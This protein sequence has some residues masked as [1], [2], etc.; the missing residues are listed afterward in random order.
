MKLRRVRYDLLRVGAAAVTT[1]AILVLN[2]SATAAAAEETQPATGATTQSAQP[3]VLEEIVVTAQRRL[4]NLQDVPITVTAMPAAALAAVG[5]TN[6]ADLVNVVPG[7]LVQ[8]SAGYSLPHLRGVGITAIG[9]GIEN[10]VALYVDGVYRGVSSSDAVGL[11]N[12]AQVEVEKGPQGTL[13]G[14]N[15]TGGLIQ[16]T[17]LDPTAGFSA[18]AHA[19]YGNYHTVQSDAY[20]S[21]GTDFVAGDLAVQLTHQGE[22]Y[23]T[24]LATGQDINRMDMSLSVR[25]KWILHPVDGT[26]LT[27]I[28]DNAETDNS[29]SALR[30]YQNYPNIYYPGGMPIANLPTLDVDDDAQPLR[31]MHEQGASLQLDQDIDTVK[32]VNTVAYRRDVYTY[33]VDFDLGPMPYSLNDTRQEDNQLTEELRLLSN[34]NSSLTWMTGLFYYGAHNGF[35]PQNIYFSGTAVNPAKPVTHVLNETVQTT[36]SLALFG[37]ATQK[38]T[39]TT[40]LTVGLRYTGE[41]RALL[42]TDTGF[43]NGVVPVPLANVNTN[44]RTN[45]PTWRL[46]LDHHFTDDVNGY[47]SYNRG[48]KSG[49]YNVP[50]PALPAYS[51]EK[52]DAYETGLKTQFLERRLTLNTAF[53]YYNYQNIQVSRF[54]N[55]SPEV[56][57]GGKARLYGLDLDATV[58][59]TQGL[60]ISAGLELEHDRFT[61]FPNADFFLS[62]AHPYPT[63]CSLS[64]NGKQLPQ[65]P[66]ASGTI[67]VDYRVSISNSELHF[68]VNEAANS[69]YYYQP[70]NEIKQSAYGLLNG[71]IGWTYGH[72]SVSLWGK[73]LTDVIYA[74]AVNPA[75]T[76]ISAAYAAPRTYG[77]TLGAKF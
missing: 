61:D 15:A 33:D 50:A 29:L 4:E 26:K 58:R 77:V 42:G 35:Q 3:A 36:N 74:T 21:G 2:P 70:N 55:G 68:N 20:V 63:V 22:G 40:E 1:Q 46:A 12:I 69:G 18:S 39:E 73:N 76:A 44:F 51:P 34:G 7:M 67:N 24:N 23:G 47:V 62:C 31:R 57:N 27:L 13:F 75:P 64:A 19:G 16:V 72:Y 9:A 56:Y 32:L 52:L 5:I 45:T 30:N 37:Q 71:S 41:K 60:T 59:V 48:F 8:T 11:N 28:L 14:R 6:T 38:L 10:S 65:T 54:V 49:G 17:T 53:F 43:L 66:A 25:S